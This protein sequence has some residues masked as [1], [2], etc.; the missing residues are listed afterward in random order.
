MHTYKYLRVCMFS[1]LSVGLFLSHT[2]FSLHA[3]AGGGAPPF[4]PSPFLPTLPP[5]LPVSF[6]TA[7]CLSVCT[8][9]SSLSLSVYTH[10]CT[11]AHL[12]LSLCI[13]THISCSD[14]SLSVHTHMCTYARI[15]LSVYTHIRVHVHISLSLCM[16]TYM[17]L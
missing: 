4:P 12:S 9:T 1:L 15:V 6:S 16:H 3:G 8:L 13:H 11:Y 2:I 7:R 5:P 14:L 10:M 17:F